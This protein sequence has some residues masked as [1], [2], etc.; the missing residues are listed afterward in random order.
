M[1]QAITERLELRVIQTFVTHQD[2]DVSWVGSRM[3]GDVLRKE[4]VH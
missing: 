1:R 4:R 2:G 3:A